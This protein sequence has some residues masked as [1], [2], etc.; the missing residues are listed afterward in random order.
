M[1]DEAYA[2]GVDK[3]PNVVQWMKIRG[4]N[5]MKE[6]LFTLVAQG[7][8]KIDEAEVKQ[9][10]DRRT[11]QITA[12][13]MVLPT[14][15]QAN[16]LRDSLNAGVPFGDLAP[17]YSTCVSGA[18]EGNLGAVRWGDFSDT[19][20]T[21][22]FA[23]EPGE[24]SRPFQVED[25]Y[26]IIMVETKMNAE[27]ADPAAEEQKIRNRL[28]RDATF[29][30][31]QS[32][33]DSL[34]IA[35][36]VDMNIPNLVDLCARYAETTIDMGLTG[37]VIEV[38]VVPPMTDSERAQPIVSFENGGFSTGDVIDLIISQ[39]YVVRPKLDD[40]DQM[41]PFINRQ[42]NDTLVIR[43]AYKRELDKAPAVADQLE[44]L[45]QKRM[46]MRF[47]NVVTADLV[48]P[49]DSLRKFYEAHASDFKIQEGNYGS[50]IVLRSRAAADS[51]LERLNQGESF[52]ELARERSVDPFTAPGGG[53]MGFSA[54][55]KDEEFDGFFATMEEG[56]TKIFRSV[57][58]HVVLH[59]R[60][61]QASR[62]PTYE[63]ARPAAEQQLRPKYREKALSDWITNRREEVNVTTYDELLAELDLTS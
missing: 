3:H 23:L 57:E 13:H 9:F 36:Q 53:D 48:V 25:G 40:P 34:R 18:N 54:K 45:K 50:K 55:G 16:A 30:E 4:T 37:E 14:L 15:E 17:R 19:W 60:K 58:G 42:L 56:E 10:M 41:I 59:L 49:E 6:Y 24:I 29:A 35:Y 39:P 1:L 43:E 32:F 63:E 7:R 33:L 51:V 21:H 8:I 26:C 47:Y 11:A 31:R 52:E 20:S 27:L 2:M 12:R 22:A 62:L 5:I 38:D 46:L 28:I 44:K 61:H